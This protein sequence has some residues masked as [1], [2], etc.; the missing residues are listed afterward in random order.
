[1]PVNYHLRPIEIR[2]FAPGLWEVSDWLMP[3]SAAQEMTDC[4]PQPGGGLRAFFRGTALSTSGIV[5]LTKERVIGL[6]AR[7]GVPLRSGGAGDGIDRYLVTYSFSPGAT[8]PRLYRMDGSNSET[9]WTQIFVTSGTTLFNQA[10]NDNNA[11]Q[12]ASFRFFRLSSGAPNDRYVL[13]VL[14]YVAPPSQGPGL[15][16]LNYNDLSTVQKAIEL[17]TSVSGSTRPWGPIATH[18]ARVLV[19][20]GNSERIIWSD[21][22][23]VTFG[24][25][26]FLD[27]EPNQDLPVIIAMHSNAPDDLIVMKEGG[28]FAVVQGN[29]TSAVVQQM[30][31]GIHPGGSGN[32]DFGRSPFGMLFIATDGGV[33][34]TNGYEMNNLSAQLSGFNQQ[35]DFVG[36]GDTNYIGDFV[37]A[38]RGYV[39]HVPTQSWFKQTQIAGALH[40]I[41]RYTRMIWGPTTTG[42]NFGLRQLSPFP[43]SARLNTFSW[44]SAPLR[45]D[46]GR[47]LE[48]RE[49]E[50]VA[51]PYGANATIAVTVN[52]VT[53]TKTLA[54]S[55]TR[56]D[57]S[58]L[59]N[60]RGEVLDVRVVSTAG[61]SNQEA[62][63]IEA[64][65]IY[66]RSGH[67]TY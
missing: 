37:F 49:V 5:D 15:Y 64:V 44:K 67:Q 24:A 3:A 29:I 32:Q 53:V 27:V 33:Y 42:T 28:P 57:V 14:R 18:Q 22:G 34:A 23:T 21:P 26:N 40:N 56:Q 63:S 4:Y 52:G 9:T 1:V 58:F 7:G 39:Y 48:I 12:K 51:K 31:E 38:P 65:R 10:T 35:S 2:D 19:A 41:E 62:P 17:T 61:N 30:V 43:D 20:D 54:G 66:S 47:Q 59:F 8:R 16:R 46:D 11:P 6:H 50:V 13:M 55:S 60:Q 25:A 45:S 36:P